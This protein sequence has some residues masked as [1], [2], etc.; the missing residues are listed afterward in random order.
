M[1]N[2]V[3]GSFNNHLPVKVR[4]GENISE[5]I[6]DVIKEVASKKAFLMVDQG[7]ERFNPAAAAQIGRAHV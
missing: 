3:L 4:F 5:T 7:I 2:P 1:T 6:P